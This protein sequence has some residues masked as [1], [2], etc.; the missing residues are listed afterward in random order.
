M[1]YVHLSQV[2]ER[3]DVPLICVVFELLALLDVSFKSFALL[4]LGF[5]DYTH[6]NIALRLQFSFDELNHHLSQY[7]GELNSD[8][9]HEHSN[10]CVVLLFKG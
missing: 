5:G 6:V 9:F 1:F 7:R 3:A 4:F 2:A 8:L 10:V